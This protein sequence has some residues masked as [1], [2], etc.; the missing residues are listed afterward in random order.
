MSKA[1]WLKCAAAGVLS[2]ACGGQPAHAIIVSAGAGQGLTFD[3]SGVGKV[4]DSTDFYGTGTLVSPIHV[5]TAAHLVDGLSADGARFDVNGVSY[6]SSSIAIHPLYDGGDAHDLAVITLSAPATG[7]SYYAFNHGEIIETA[8]GAIAYKVGFGFGGGGAAGYDETLYPYGDK[9]VGQNVVDLIPALPTQL[10][11]GQ[12]NSA[13]VEA[14]VL[15]YDFDNHTAGTNGPLGGPAVGP[16]EANTTPGDS[17]GAMF[18]Y[19]AALARF[20]LTG[21]T[22]SGLDDYSRFGDIGIDARVSSHADWIDQQVP[23]PS[24]ALIA[25]GGLFA[26]TV[27]RRRRQDTPILAA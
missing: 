19:D 4:G 21:V 6:N 13:T 12:G 18:H 2:L 10:T 8:P 11:D 15:L 7:A 16:Q 27:R 26:A 5:V 22:V 23:E 1:G 24:A 3:W 14:G 20:V 17:G 25:A 9:R